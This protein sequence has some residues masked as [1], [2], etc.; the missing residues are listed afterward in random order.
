MKDCENE[1]GSPCGSAISCR[2]CTV[3]HVSNKVVMIA[4]Q[5]L[6][7]PLPLEPAKRR[8]LTR[9]IQHLSGLVAMSVVNIQTWGIK[10]AVG[11]KGI[12]PAADEFVNGIR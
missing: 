12:P 3:Q 10:A 8:Q 5:V 4:E 11:D 2:V 1:K 7:V 6:G 9:P